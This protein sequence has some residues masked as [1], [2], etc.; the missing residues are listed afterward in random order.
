M[1]I[2][3]APFAHAVREALKE[4]LHKDGIEMDLWMDPRPADQH[5]EPWEPLVKAAEQRRFQAFIAT[6]VDTTHAP[7]AAEIARA[8]GLS[9][10]A[11]FGSQ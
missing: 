10:S 7:V 11:S 9:G 6:E 2:K 8:D 4:E 3:E 5:G 1:S